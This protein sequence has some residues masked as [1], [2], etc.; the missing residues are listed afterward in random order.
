MGESITT[1]TR[2]ELCTNIVETQKLLEHRLNT[3]DFEACPPTEILPHRAA[4]F[5]S[6]PLLDSVILNKE[7]VQR[8]QIYL[9]YIYIHL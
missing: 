6:F 5:R 2:Y 4:Y 9:I 7:P 8:L 3:V 1:S